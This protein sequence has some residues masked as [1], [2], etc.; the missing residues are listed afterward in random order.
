M[1]ADSKE[2]PKKRHFSNV[3]SESSPEFL[4]LP[5]KAHTEINMEAMQKTL[6]GMQTQLSELLSIKGTIE[7]TQRTVTSI[8]DTLTLLTAR[9]DK[10][11]KQCDK[12]TKLY[13]DQKKEN[14]LL[15]LRFKVLDEK[16][17]QAETYSRRD[18]LIFD[19]IPEPQDETKWDLYN[20]ILD[21]LR[22][23]MKFHQ[24][25]DIK[26]VRWHRYGR[27]YGNKPR[28]VMVKFHFFPDKER[29]WDARKELKNTDIWVSEDFPVE[30]KNRRQVLMPIYR[31]ALRTEGVT[32]S[33]NRDRLF[34]NGNMFTINNLHML[35]AGLKLQNTSIANIEGRACFYT[36]SAPFSNFFPAKFRIGGVD[37]TCSEQYYLST[38][39]EIVGDYEVAEK[40]MLESD[41]AVMKSLSNSLPH[42]NNDMDK[43][44][45]GL[46]KQTMMDALV[47][48][49]SQNPHLRDCLVST[50]DSEIVEASANDLFWGAGVSL[51]NIGSKP[52]D[53][54]PGQ[55]VLG[56][57][58]QEVRT[59]LST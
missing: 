26:F 51:K 6:I 5:K 28:A 7:G 45:E 2:T 16:R 10:A 21:V 59:T 29:V 8:N 52:K 34:L 43:L 49:F 37:Y 50:G 31:A 36:R 57:L 24:V 27:S 39:A 42:R 40:I 25:E 11:E 4:C 22:V 48:K 58:L 15:K 33:L 18:N 53:D 12:I 13:E 47:A 19:G 41:P 46:K 1:S 14:N 54:W 17:I 3:S 32:A 35:P 38:G 44:T 20:K 9:L 23:K 55:N 30:I 56:S